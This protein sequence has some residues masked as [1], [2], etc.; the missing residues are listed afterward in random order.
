MFYFCIEY[1]ICSVYDVVQWVITL[2]IMAWLNQKI[3]GKKSKLKI[4]HY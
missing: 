3:H 1:I 4:I 2:Q